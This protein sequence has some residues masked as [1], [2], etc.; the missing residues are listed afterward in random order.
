MTII[1]TFVYKKR[2]LICIYDNA[3]DDAD[4]AEPKLDSIA[5]E[6][7]YETLLPR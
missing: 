2:V 4:M 3:F 6:I 1:D 7:V 5:V